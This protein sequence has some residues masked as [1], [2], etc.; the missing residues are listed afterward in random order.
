VATRSIEI[1][2]AKRNLIG[3]AVV[4][5][6]VWLFVVPIMETAHCPNQG[7]EQSKTVSVKFM[8]ASPENTG[9]VTMW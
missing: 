3:V 2:N 1:A 6:H 9:V 7:A 5:P 4:R 8:I